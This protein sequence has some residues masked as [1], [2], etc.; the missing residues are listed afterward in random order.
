[1]ESKQAFIFSFVLSLAFVSFVLCIVA[2]F[3]RSTENDLKLDGKLCHLPESHAYRF[4]I[5]ALTCLAAAQIIGNLLVLTFCTNTKNLCCFFPTDDDEEKMEHEKKVPIFTRKPAIA[6][7][8]MVFSWLSF[9]IALL[10]ISVAASMNK[11]QAYGEGWLDGECYLVKDGVFTGAAVLV[12]LSISSTL[13]SAFFLM[14]HKQ[15]R[16]DRAISK[17]QEKLSQI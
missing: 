10:L 11:L 1:M 5:A 17:S 9:G 8:L 12:I 6:A 16:S 3:K 7:A 15:E 13:G 4:G 2:D 14:R